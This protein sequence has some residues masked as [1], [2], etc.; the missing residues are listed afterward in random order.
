MAKPLKTYKTVNLPPDVREKLDVL[1][2][3]QTRTVLGELTVL[4]NS[5]YK[6]HMK[7]SSKS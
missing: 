1:A 6:L 5:A 4:I 7:K 3:A 2:K